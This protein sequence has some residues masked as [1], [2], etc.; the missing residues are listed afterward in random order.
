MWQQETNPLKMAWALTIHKSQG[1]TLSKETID[2]GK[3]ERQGLTFTT[4]S[5]VKSLACLHISPFFSFDRYAK[6]Q[7]SAFV[8]LRKEEEARLDALSV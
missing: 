7:D 2:I 5:R 1:L 8:A 3:V 6:M 4:I